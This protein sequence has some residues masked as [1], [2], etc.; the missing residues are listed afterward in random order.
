M[1]AAAAAAPPA[2]AAPG[3]RA[4]AK[5][6]AAGQMQTRPRPRALLP[7]ELVASAARQG[8]PWVLTVT[9]AGLRC[10]GAPVMVSAH[11]TGACS[12]Q[13]P[14][15]RLSCPGGARGAP[16]LETYGAGGAAA[17]ASVKVAAG[18]RDWAG[19]GAAADNSLSS[20]V[21]VAVPKGCGPRSLVA[22]DAQG[23]AECV[24][25]PSP[26]T[27][28][29]AAAPPRAA[30]ARGGGAEATGRAAPGAAAPGGEGVPARAALKA[31][32]SAV[33]VDDTD[34]GCI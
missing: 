7:V 16:R 29:A 18:A 30:A 34:E 3:G 21:L 5:Q 20:C 13:A 25:Y 28:A 22:V 23:A 19:C 32:L 33:P 2:G 27:A 12:T 8:N 26:A 24:P 9:Y 6:Q 4:G 15:G 1:A 17:C 11:L 10:G 31:A 14:A